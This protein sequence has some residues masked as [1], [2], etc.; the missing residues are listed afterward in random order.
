MTVCTYM[1]M[2]LLSCKIYILTQLRNK[3]ILS[4]AR[5]MTSLAL[6]VVTQMKLK[7]PYFCYKIFVFYY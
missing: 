5:R 4:T 3:E 7:C 1:Y 6:A 2:L